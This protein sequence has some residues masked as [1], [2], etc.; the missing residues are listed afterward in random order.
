MNSERK[1]VC[2]ICGKEAMGIKCL[3][4]CSTTVCDEHA[5]SMLRAM[6]PGEKKEW[7]ICYFHR[8][9]IEPDS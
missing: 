8:F 2:D 3:G 1:P 5:E 9:P 6:K 7:G 4:C